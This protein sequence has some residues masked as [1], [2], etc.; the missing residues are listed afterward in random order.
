MQLLWHVSFPEL[1]PIL[2]PADYTGDGRVDK[3][4]VMQLLWHVSFPE[5]YPLN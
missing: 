4:D 1:Y 2:I 5:L 3:E